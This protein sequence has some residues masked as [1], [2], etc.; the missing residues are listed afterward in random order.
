LQAGK[1]GADPKCANNYPL[2]II[3]PQ[4]PPC[5]Y[6]YRLTAK[7]IVARV[8]VS[9]NAIRFNVFWKRL[10]FVEKQR[11][12]RHLYYLTLKNINQ[13]ETKC[14]KYRHNN[15]RQDYVCKTL[16]DKFRSD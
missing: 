2:E 14:P 3:I 12:D 1:M 16:A 13:D 8:I 9:K 6:N 5:P 10:V 11:C 15:K 7:T 4:E